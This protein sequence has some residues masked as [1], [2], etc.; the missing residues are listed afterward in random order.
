MNTRLYACAAAAECIRDAK[1]GK[2]RE[3]IRWGV[4]LAKG[5]VTWDQEIK[6]LWED[7]GRLMRD[8]QVWNEKKAARLMARHCVAPTVD[9]RHVTNFLANKPWLGTGINACM[10]P[11]YETTCF[12]DANAKGIALTIWEKDDWGLMPI[13]ADAMEDTGRATE[14]ALEHLRGEHKHWPGCWVVREA[15]L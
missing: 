13:L 15:V 9:P 5:R 14:E 6:R 8:Y 10:R 3:A 7:I 2:C 4:L 1:S 12:D 11:H